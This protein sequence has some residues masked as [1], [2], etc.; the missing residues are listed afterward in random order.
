MLRIFKIPQVGVAHTLQECGEVSID[1]GTGHE[2]RAASRAAISVK[3]AG[4][5]TMLLLRQER[6]LQ[7][8][9]LELT[10]EQKQGQRQ[11]EQEEARWRKSEDHDGRCVRGRNGEPIKLEDRRQV[12]WT[13]S[14]QRDWSTNAAVDAIVDTVNWHT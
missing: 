1:D 11:R 14:S 7:P 9:L 13:R 6:P 3:E 10:K 5:S 4:N 8:P 2:W 12:W